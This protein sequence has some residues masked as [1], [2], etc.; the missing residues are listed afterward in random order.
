MLLNLY[1][2]IY[3]FSKQVI[4][5]LSNLEVYEMY[6]HILTIPGICEPFDSVMCQNKN[7]WVD[8]SIED[9]KCDA[10]DREDPAGT[11]CFFYISFLPSISS[12]TTI[13]RLSYI[14]PRQHGIAATCILIV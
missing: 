8:C 11:E 13:C 10:L 6:I 5:V 1:Q 4:Y 3:F 2:E 9:F 12:D 14:I 7:T